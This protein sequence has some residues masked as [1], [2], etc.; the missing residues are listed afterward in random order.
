MDRLG[1][2]RKGTCEDTQENAISSL[3]QS[4]DWG[5][6]KWRSSSKERP[7]KE[8]DLQLTQQ[9]SPMKG[10]A[11]FVSV[12]SNLGAVVAAEERAIGSISGNE[13]RIAQAW[14]NVRGGVRVFSMCFWHSDGWTP[15]NE[16]L[17]EAVVKQAQTTRHPW[18]AAGN[19]KHVPRRRRE[20][21]VVSKESDACS[22]SGRSVH[23]QVKCAQGEWIE[24]QK[25]TLLRVSV[26]EDKFHRLTTWKTLNQDRIKQCRSWWRERERRKYRNGMSRSWQMCCLATVEEGCQKEERGRAGE[27]AGEECKERQI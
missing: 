13:G 7:R 4:A 22:A 25:I 3:R 14:V 10:Q 19:A 1:V 21:P 17:L 16:L 8:G 24:R 26:S 2:Q 6:R 23:M 18:L 15:R 27:K 20:G 11:V 9:E 12:N 5:R